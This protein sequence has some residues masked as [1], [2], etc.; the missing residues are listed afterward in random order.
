MRCKEVG[1]Q[2]PNAIQRWLR[3]DFA[4]PTNDM[5]RNVKQVL[6]SLPAQTEANQLEPTLSHILYEASDTPLSTPL[7]TPLATP[8][9][10]PPSYSTGQV[11]LPAPSPAIDI[12]QPHRRW[13]WLVIS[14][15]L[16][17]LFFRI[18]LIY[19]REGLMLNDLGYYLALSVMAMTPLL[20]WSTLKSL[21]QYS[22]F[23]NQLLL[24]VS[25]WMALAALYFFMTLRTQ[26]IS[27]LECLFF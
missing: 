5:L 6:D 3:K 15:L 10:F 25:G 19:Q 9:T 16:G 21:R 17:Y 18:D 4:Q 11:K 7:N 13:Q 24:V 23:M 14:V 1:N 20:A 8:L 27:W 22:R 12:P 26:G 2:R